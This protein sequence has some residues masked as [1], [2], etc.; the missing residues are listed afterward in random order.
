MAKSILASKR[1][2][3]GHISHMEANCKLLEE[4]GFDVRF[5]VNE[6]FL[7]FPDC[8][9]HGKASGFSDWVALRRGDLLI[10]WYASVSVVFNLVFVRLFTRAT[11]VYIYHEPYTSFSSYRAAGFSWLKTVRVTAISMVSRVICA[12]SDKIILP[13]ER[14]FQAMPAA[15]LQPRRYAKIN[16]M[17]ADESVPETQSLARDFVSYI[18]TIAEDHAFDEFVGLMQ[19]CIADHAL[20][21]LKF[22]IATRSL[23][24]DKHRAVIDQCVSS[25]RLVL[26]ASRPMTNAEIN[27][28]YA[29]SFVVWNAYRRSM[30]SGVLPKA[31]MFG[32]PV[33][34][35][36][37]NQSE[38]FQEGVHGA[39]LSARYTLQEFQHAITWLQAVWPGI[40]RNC[41]TQYLQNFDYRA[42][43]STF[44]NFISDNP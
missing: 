28:F 23:V 18:G 29:S 33:L 13:S 15:R 10:I 30:Q 22:L 19:T 24:P 3:P 34:V 12:L 14:A 40:S 26:Q 27:H 35:S 16:L 36:T 32:T 44:M 39:L 5:S 1:F 31:Y 20:F 17:F 25:G 37:S 42:L 6:Q 21:P 41:R 4:R 7:S 9:M 2:N 8:G 11:T 38:Y 43:S